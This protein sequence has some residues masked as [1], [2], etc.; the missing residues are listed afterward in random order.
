MLLKTLISGLWFIWSEVGLLNQMAILIAGIF[1]LRNLCTMSHLHVLTSYSYQQH[2]EIPISSSVSLPVLVIFFFFFWQWAWDYITLWFCNIY[3]FDKFIHVHSGIYFFSLLPS[4]AGLLCFLFP[5]SSLEVPSSRL[6]LF[7]LSRDTLIFNQDHLC[8][9]RFGTVHW[10]LVDSPLVTLW[11]QWLSSQ[12]PSVANSWARRGRPPWAPPWFT[13]GCWQAQ[14]RA[15]RPSADSCGCYG[16]MWW[17]CHAL[18]MACPS[19]SPHLLL[20]A[21]FCSLFCYVPCA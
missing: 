5:S 4:L 8:G 16:V 21:C 2:P 17:P 12:I 10:N 14:A 20:L 3:S 18:K 13:I 6:Y 19:P 7:V 11:R 9:L 15:G 1:F